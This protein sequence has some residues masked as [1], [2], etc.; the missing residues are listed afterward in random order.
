M[1]FMVVA[2]VVPVPRGHLAR[3]RAD[4]KTPDEYVPAWALV[5][6]PSRGDGF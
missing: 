4:A 2:V 6:S 3:I 5:Q 1:R